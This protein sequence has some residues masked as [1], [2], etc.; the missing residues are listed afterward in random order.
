MELRIAWRG[1]RAFSAGRLR[2][3]QSTT[4]RCRRRRT[5][6]YWTRATRSRFQPLAM[7]TMQCILT[8]LTLHLRQRRSLGG[9]TRSARDRRLAIFQLEVA[10]AVA[11]PAT[12]NRKFE[13]PANLGAILRPRQGA[14]GSHARR[15]RVLVSQRLRGQA[16]PTLRPVAAVRAAA[17]APVAAAA[18]CRRLSKSQLRHNRQVRV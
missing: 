9:G 14:Q 18:A 6:H 5:T 13:S 16:A 17:A 4:Q 7:S 12:P 8:M 2:P 1:W 3:S 10:P 11:A 15:A